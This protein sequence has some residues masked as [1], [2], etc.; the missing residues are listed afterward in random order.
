MIDTV[1]ASQIL[2][3]TQIDRL[4]KL[5]DR[6]NK[7][8][9]N[10]AVIDPSGNCVMHFPGWRFVSDIQQLGDYGQQAYQQHGDSEKVHQFGPDGEV[11]VML[12]KAA[13]T[14]AAIAVVDTGSANA[15]ANEDLARLCMQY[16]IDY[17]LLEKAI[18]SGNREDRFYRDI[19]IAFAEE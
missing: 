9:V 15:I 8:E 18:K 11:F 5:A 19:L 6:V 3:P 17:A 1:T 4:E 7:F 10:L 2:T 13:D 16:K 14:I 12:L